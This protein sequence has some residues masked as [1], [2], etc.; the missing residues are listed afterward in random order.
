MPR[1]PQ[2]SWTLEQWALTDQRAWKTALVKGD[3][4][5]PGGEAS[6][7]RESTARTVMRSYGHWLSWAAKESLL[8]VNAGPAQPLTPENVKR[9]ITSIREK[10]ASQTVAG[11]VSQIYMAAKVMMPAT[12]WQ[13]LRDAWLRLERRAK[14][15]R[16]KNARL[17]DPDELLRCGIEAM[18]DAEKSAR[19]R[20][21]SLATLFRDGLMV[22]TLAYRPFRLANITSIELG[23]HLQRLGEV[24]WLA[25]KANETKTSCAIEAPFPDELVPYLQRYLDH[26]RPLLLRNPNSDPAHSRKLWLSTYGRGLCENMVYRR[27][28]ELT[29]ERL[30]RAINPHAFRHAAATSIAFADPEHVRITKSILGHGSLTSSERYYNLAQA[31]EAAR[32][33]N[34]QIRRLRGS[35]RDATIRP[36]RRARS[37]K[38]MKR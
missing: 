15:L 37:S 33:Y 14:P 26:Y 19:A 34:E 8:D 18:E 6:H 22:A 4:L 20:L 23:R 9:Y 28:M 3:V 11:R 29:E 16:D 10:L 38:P 7:W 12:D 21:C 17:A 35:A 25:F 13:W 31:S 1:H 27:I 32:R 2:K 30:G 24:Y 36:R 5:E